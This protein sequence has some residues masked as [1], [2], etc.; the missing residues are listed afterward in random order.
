M[1]NV[2]TLLLA[3]FIFSTVTVPQAPDT[4]WTRKI[5]GTGIDVGNEIIQ[6]SDGGFVIAGYTTSFGAIQRDSYIIKLDSSGSTIWANRYG[7]NDYEIAT[8]VKETQDEGY[9]FS[10][11][12][13]TASNVSLQLIKVNSAGDT[14][15]TKFVGTADD[16]VA[17]N[18]QTTNDGGFLVTGH[19]DAAALTNG[20]RDVWLV[21]LDSLGNKIWERTYGGPEDDGGYKLLN[22]SD[23]NLIIAGYSESFSSG[24][25]RDGWIVK[26]NPSGNFMWSKSF[27]SGS[28]DEFNAAA[29]DEDG[30]LYFTGTTESSGDRNLWIVK[31]DS[32]GNHILTKTYGGAQWEWGHDI[33]RTNDGNFIVTGYS[34]SNSSG[35][36]QLW[37]LK[38]DE[39]ADTL[40]TKLIRSTNGSEGYSV[41]QTPDN[42][43]AVTG[44]AASSGTGPD[45]W[46]IRLKPEG[47]SGIED[48]IF[49]LP[50][51]FALMQNYP[52]PFNPATSI[53]YAISIM[54]FV[55]IKV[56]DILG[57][58][59]ITLVTEEKPAGVYEVEFNA[60]GLAS[61][62]YLYKLQAGLFVETKKMI[63][64]R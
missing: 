13:S 50:K 45:V 15:W 53:K 56:Y 36:K 22:L 1:K 11:F 16:E 43:F 25:D 61:G 62:M 63:L 5:G 17:S 7:G 39:Q 9:I 48:E 20:K 10:V 49:E 40:W 3:V 29:E 58:E 55:Q 12:Y 60:S 38:I 8:S 52:N 57:N 46:V 26:T 14:L 51:T 24:G 44:V 47:T 35:L 33:K 18:L 37:I 27:G 23:G 21:K 59:I 19:T 31:T 54:R 34:Q 2:Y 4:L 30:N 41:I 32:A 64:L 42:G 6:T 28:Y